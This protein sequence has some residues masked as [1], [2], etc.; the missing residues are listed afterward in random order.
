M[1]DSVGM[2]PVVSLVVAQCFRR[3]SSLPRTGCYPVRRSPQTPPIECE[4]GSEERLPPEHGLVR[5]RRIH[6]FPADGRGQG[7]PG[8]G[9]AWGRGAGA[10][11]GAGLGSGNQLPAHAPCLRLA[12]RRRA[13]FAGGGKPSES[14]IRAWSGLSEAGKRCRVARI[15]RLRS[16]APVPCGWCPVIRNRVEWC[17]KREFTHRQGLA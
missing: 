1:A 8:P 14:G 7:I 12:S 16:C 5:R 4:L 3:A 6:G 2:T 10:G 13:V 11:A 15:V 17:S 9:L